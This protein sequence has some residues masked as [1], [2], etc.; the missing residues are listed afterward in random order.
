MKQ[1]KTSRMIVTL[2]L[3][4]GMLAGPNTYGGTT[5]LNGGTLTLANYYSDDELAIAAD[6]AINVA[7]NFTATW[8]GALSGSGQLTKSGAG[9]LRLTAASSGYS[10]AVVLATDG[11]RLTLREGGTLTGVTSFTVNPYATLLM[12]DTAGRTVGRLLARPIAL[13]GGTLQFNAANSAGNITQSV[14]AVTLSAASTINATAAGQGAEL[15]LASLTRLVGDGTVNFTGTALGTSGNN[16]R[17]YITQINTGGGLAT[18]TGNAFLGGW[19]TVNNHD[20]A[21]YVTGSSTTGGVEAYGGPNGAPAYTALSTATA[22]GLNGWT[23]GNVGNMTAAATLGTVGPG[24]VFSVGAL[25]IDNSSGGITFAGTTGTPD[26]LHVESGGIIGGNA[27]AAQSIGA[28]TSL[29]TRGI[30]TAGAVGLAGS[31]PVELFIYRASN[32][33]TINSVITD[34]PGGGGHALTLIKSS[35]MNSWQG[36]ATLNAAN[37]YSGGT[38]V[39]GSVLTAN[40]TG[41]LG[42]GK[43]SVNNALLTLGAVNAT[44]YVGSLADPE[45]TVVNGAQL[46]ITSGNHGASEFYNIGANSVISGTSAATSGLASLTRGTTITLAS[47]AIIAHNTILTGALSLTTGTI[48][49]LGTDADLFYGLNNTQNNIGGAITIG[50]GTAFRG[51]STDRTADRAWEKGTININTGTASVDFQ[52]ATTF[53]GVKQLVLGNGASADAPVINFVSGTGTLDIKAIGKLQLNDAT[54]VYGNTGASQNVRFVATAGSTLTVTTA[55]GMGS[56]T[57]IASALINNGGILAVGNTT[58]LNGNVTVEAGGQFNASQAAGLTGT[59]ALTFNEGSILEISNATGFS[60]AQA[61]AATVPAGT[62]VRMNTGTFTFGAAG[63]TLDSYLSSKSPIYQI[64]N[65]H[66]A[67]NP[68]NPGTTILTLNKNGSGVGGILINGS[69]SKTFGNSVNGKITLGTNGGIMAGTTG[70][71]LVVTE[72]IDGA[73]SLTIGTTNIIDGAPKRGSVALGS[74]AGSNTYTGGTIINAGTLR[75][76]YANVLGALT[77]QLTVNTGGTLNMG[78]QAL[79]VGNLT[80]TG[81]VIANGGTLTIGQGDNGGGNFQGSIQNSTAL[82]KTGAG[83][84]TL[85]GANTYTGATTISGGGT[86]VLDYSSQDNSKLSDSA[87]LT[88]SNGGGNLILSN[89]NH[90]EVVASTALGVMNNG[91]GHFAITSVGGTSKISLGAITRAS[92]FSGNNGYGTTMSI[93]QDNL[94]TTTSPVVNGILGGGITVGSNWAKVSSLNIVA[95]TSGDYTPLPTDAGAVIATVNYQ[96]TGG[97]TRTAGTSINSLR[98]VSDADSQELN[99][100]A[101]NLSFFTNAGGLL[102]VGGAYNHYTIKGTGT[103]TISMQNG[104]QETIINVYDG[105]LIVETRVGSG[106]GI[107][108]KSGTGTLVLKGASIYT[109]ATT[110]NQGTLLANNTTGSATGTGNVTVNNGAVLGGTGTIGGNV[111]IAAG[112]G[113]TFDLTTAFGSHDKLELAATKTLTFSGTSTLTITASGILTEPGI[114][115][116]VTAP[117][118][119]SGTLPA[120]VNLPTDYAATVQVTGNDLELNVTG[121]PARGGPLDY[122]EFSAITSP[123]EAGTPITG[124]TLT[125]KDA[126]GLTANFNGT[127]AFSG[128]AGIT[129][130]SAAFTQGVLAGL[131]VTPTVADSG[132][133]FTVTDEV[134]GKHGTATFDVSPGALDHFTIS[135]IGSPQTAGTAISGITLTAQDA[136]NNTVTGFGDTVTYDGTAGISG[137]SASFTA[138]VLA[139]VSVTPTVAGSGRTFIVTASGKTGARTFNVD[140]GAV[141]HFAI[142]GFTP[143]GVVGTPVTGITITAQDANNNTVTGFG[144][145]VTYGGTAGITGMSGNFAAGVLADVSVTPREAGTGVSFTVNDGSGH[146]G[147]EGSDVVWVNGMVMMAA[148]SVQVNT[149]APVASVR[150]NSPYPPVT[151]AITGGRDATSFNLDSGTGE[152]TLKSS[153]GSVGTKYYVLVRATDNNAN[154]DSILVEVTSTG[155]AVLSGS[156]F[157]FR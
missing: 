152:L 92:G 128:T 11:G 83:T 38:K 57:G 117:G 32:S 78:G 103:S 72:N 23:S 109:A 45:Y 100:N 56:G 52:G 111:T 53:D 94:A 74:A 7:R 35:Q 65:D 1:V 75:Q 79:T 18:P 37:T 127:V 41:S 25:R 125:A 82:T 70:T 144:G 150:A 93:S 16:S 59:G 8:N 20:F 39:L 21:T 157:M 62:I 139:G 106:I 154:V 6:S 3:V 132:R 107:V 54:A 63:D 129:G 15:T 67:V 51:I 145:T 153:A 91:G 135:A 33:L 30:L 146:T 31:A 87:A 124:I 86:L 140:P 90:T 114:Y 156:V 71:E 137:T 81:G 29:A 142:T 36:G 131:S 155:A 27:N 50:T 24:Q 108:T 69:A 115:T 9:D 120:T 58:S 98:I 116:L 141:H 95:L 138:G 17:I 55:T 61:T 28:T 112:G 143:T 47:G 80:G 148:A 10:G 122:F 22:P 126:G 46:A 64:I 123:Q 48:K 2:A 110:V 44:S 84:N 151:Y 66:T 12:D 85:S 13:Q 99:L 68:T 42:S 147:S 133:T 130:D 113:L 136:N 119:I 104:N 89:G 102:Y 34:N 43:V 101:N 26:T 5:T 149:T 96:L 60:G 105:T 4:V 97:L 76:G 121:V 19:A 118:G 88:I 77:N 134:S 40:I 73:G 49:T 14:G